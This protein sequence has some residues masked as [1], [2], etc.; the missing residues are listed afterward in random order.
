MP[1]AL[2][3]SAS[4]KVNGT[5]LA[6]TVPTVGGAVGDVLVFFL[7]HTTTSLWNIPSGLTQGYISRNFVLSTAFYYR[8]VQAGDPTSYTFTHT[9]SVTSAGVCA[10]YSGVD[11]TNPIRFWANELG[12][13]NVAVTSVPFATVQ[14]VGATDLSVA[15]FGGRSNSNNVSTTMTAP[16]GWNQRESL[17]QNAGGVKSCT[18]MLCDK[19]AGT[20]VPSATGLNGFY[21]AETVVLADAANPTLN[22]PRTSPTFQSSSTAAVTT[23]TT[24]LVVNAPSGVTD[25]DLL[26]AFASN[27]NPDTMTVTGSWTNLEREGAPIDGTSIT[28]S[29][30]QAWF[31]VA[32]GEPSSYTLTSRTS[33]KMCI[34]IVRYSGCDASTPI[35]TISSTFANTISTTSPARPGLPYVQTTDL[36]VASYAAASDGTTSSITVTPPSSPWNTLANVSTAVAATFNAGLAVVD[37]FGAASTP[38]ATASATSGWCVFSIALV[39][40]QSVQQLL[41][42]RRLGPNYRR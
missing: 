12:D 34:A 24:S 35:R 25:G 29:T 5:S 28:D 10:R 22:V 33:T 18:A 30:E 7:A 23:A 3:G 4:N 21:V 37:Q 6:I 32:S 8:V 11:Q 31:R 14:N 38:T 40:P 13:S 2:V 39:G 27:V 15:V 17:T 36:I 41:P 42:P 26:L 16:A 1:I 9:G 19:T 20:D